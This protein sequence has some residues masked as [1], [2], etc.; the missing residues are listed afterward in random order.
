MIYRKGERMTSCCKRT[1][2]GC[3]SFKGSPHFSITFTGRKKNDIRTDQRQF[4]PFKY[5][6]TLSPRPGPTYDETC[7]SVIVL[8]VTTTV[9]SGKNVSTKPST[10]TDD[11]SVSLSTV[12]VLLE[13]L[14]FL[15]QKTFSNIDVSGVR[16]FHE[17]SIGEPV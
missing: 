11:R 3:C 14:Q 9:E 6:F 7:V 1:E 15:V 17:T 2:R 13:V 5:F 10:L 12:S 8:P 16:V 4:Y